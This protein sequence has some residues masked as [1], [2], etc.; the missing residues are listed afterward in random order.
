MYDVSVSSCITF[1]NRVRRQHALRVIDVRVFKYKQ[2]NLLL[3][4]PL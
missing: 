1:N 3:T 2:Y 4:D